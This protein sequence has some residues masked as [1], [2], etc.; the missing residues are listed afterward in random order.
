MVKQ[1]INEN[2]VTQHLSPAWQKKA[3]Y[4][5]HASIEEEGLPKKWEQLW[6]N[7]LEDGYYQICCIPFAIIYDLALGD[8]VEIDSDNIF[9]KV[10]KQSGNWTIRVWFGDVKE[11]FRESEKVDAIDKVRNQLGCLVEWH[12]TNT[13]AINAESVQVAKDIVNYFKERQLQTGLVY[14]TGWS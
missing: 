11:E 10:I 7:K 9:T 6:V 13:L 14:E 2:D 3:N 1:M 4:L 8:I 5:I 12:S